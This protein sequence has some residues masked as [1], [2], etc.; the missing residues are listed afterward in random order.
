MSKLSSD[1]QQLILHEAKARLAAQNADDFCELV[2]KDEKGQPIRQA[3]IHREINWHIDECRKRNLN[4][5]ILAPWRHGKTEQVVIARTLQFLGENPN[6]RVFIVCNADDN[7]AARVESI[8]KYIEYDKDYHLVYPE[9]RPGDKTEWGRHKLMVQRQSLS[10]DGSVEAWGITSSGTGAGCDFLIVDDPVDLRNAVLNPALRI[11]VKDAFRNVWSSRLAP[12]GFKIYIATAWHNDDLTAEMLKNSEWCFLVIKVSDD[13]S[14]MDCESP[15]KGKFQIPLWSLWP[16]EKLVAR[17]RE[18][19]TRA[20]NRGYRQC[21]LSDE[22]RTLPHYLEVFKYGVRVSDLVNPAWPR[23]AGMDPF[24]KFVVIFTL[25]L[26]PDGRRYPVEI[27]RGKWNSTEAVM[28]LIDAFET[29]RHQLIVV[30]NNASQDAIIQWAMEKGH[31]IPIWPFTTG[32]Q[33]ADPLIGLPGLD[34][35]F[36]NDSWACAM[37]GEH[38][39][40]CGCGFC[41]WKREMSEHPIGECADTVMASWFAREAARAL[42]LGVTE[43]MHPDIITEEDAGLERVEIG[44]Y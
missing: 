21:A 31:N 29:H 26:G 1:E 6:N 41:V 39:P 4:C 24:G 14:C 44:N 25:A 33:K 30:E 3:D 19:G 34:V 37:G 43:E 10:K 20:F 17:C 13:F 40:D 5:G 32:K 38:Q 16:K 15:L 23:V 35:E 7:A 42:T 22:D 12:N 2:L 28:Q 8:S 11:Q 9:V 36:A 27:R 18:I